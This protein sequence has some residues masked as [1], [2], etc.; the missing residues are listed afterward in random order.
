ML[1]D[2]KDFAFKGNMIDMAVGIIIGGAFGLTIKSLVGNIL[3]PLITGL[4]KL[5]DFKQ[6]FHALDGKEYATLEAL[7]KAGA[8]AVKYGVFI[9]DVINLLIIAFS[10]FIMV[11]YVVNAMKK[12]QEEEPEAPPEPSKEE[13]LLGEIRDVLKA[14]G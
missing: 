9:N 1:Q 7:D 10:L 3:M 13:V 11:R 2:F 5:P 6:L 4:I 14:K 12:K 8:P